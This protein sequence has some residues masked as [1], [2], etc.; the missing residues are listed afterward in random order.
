MMSIILSAMSHHKRRENL[1]E[2]T[3]LPG[4]TKKQQGSVGGDVTLS[5]RKE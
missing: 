4:D 3:S 2:Q 5:F 1:I